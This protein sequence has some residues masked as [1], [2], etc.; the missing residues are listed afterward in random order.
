MEP[1]AFGG[2]SHPPRDPSLLDP[3]LLHPNASNKRTRRADSPELRP[4]PTPTKPNE[5]EATKKLSFKETLCGAPSVEPSSDLLSKINYLFY[6]VL[7]QSDSMKT[8]AEDCPIV[9]LSKERYIKMCKPQKQALVIKLMGRDLRFVALHE[10]LTK[11]W[12]PQGPITWTDV[13][14]EF[15]VLR[16]TNQVDYET[17]LLGDPWLVA[18]HYLTVQCWSL[19]FDQ[20]REGSLRIAV[21]IRLPS[22]PLSCFNKDFLA[23]LGSTFG[24]VLREDETIF[25]TSRGQFARISVEINL[26]QPLRSKF[27]LQG[28]VLPV[29]H[30]GLHQICF[31]CG[32][33]GHRQEGCPDI[34]SSS[35]STTDGAA[36]VKEIVDAKATKLDLSP[37]FG[38]W[39]IAQN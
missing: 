10:R 36:V 18:G 16:F 30:E 24:K 25:A 6:D 33:Y 11:M 7:H 5:G 19:I 13:G 27:Q 22:L 31:H 39:M 14:K 35:N 23:E 15:Y 28:R 1:L 34:P 8:S 9:K 32:K 12:K 26:N 3:P 17:V 37:K 20:E 38:P 2:T 29:E 4:I 21:W